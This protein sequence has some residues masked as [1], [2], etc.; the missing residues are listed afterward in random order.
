MG[1][2]LERKS[3]EEEQA[4]LTPEAWLPAKGR[5]IEK[6]RGRR[7]RLNRVPRANMFR[8]MGEMKRLSPPPSQT[9]SRARPFARTTTI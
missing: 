4:R 8:P 2:S 3:K 1:I 7:G 9:S 5:H 6:T